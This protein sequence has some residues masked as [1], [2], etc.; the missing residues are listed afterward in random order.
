MGNQSSYLRTNT[1]P[2]NGLIAQLGRQWK[3][4]QYWRARRMYARVA[5][6]R[7]RSL[8]LFD[9]ANRLIARNIRA[10]MPLFDRDDKG[11]R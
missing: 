10:P 7:R 1:S 9:K 6:H 5:W 8:D 2:L 3:L 4:F 11:G